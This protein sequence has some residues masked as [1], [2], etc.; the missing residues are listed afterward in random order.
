VGDR[1][2]EDGERFVAER[3]L[4][5]AAVVLDGR[6]QIADEL[7]GLL[8][9]GVRVTLAGDERDE[10]GHELT[11]ERRAAHGTGGDVEIRVVA[12][13]RALEPLQLLA[14]REP[15]LLVEQTAP[16]AVNLK[17]LGLPPRAVERE[18]QLSAE[19]LADGVVAHERLELSD[20]AG[21]RPERKVRVDALLERR[22]P[23]LL[24]PAPLRLHERLVRQ[25]RERVAAPEVERLL[26]QLGP[27]GGG[28]AGGL[29]D[30]CLEPREV[31][32][33][34]S[35]PE[36][37]AGRMRDED[38]RPERL[39]QRRDEVLQRP[40]GL[41]GRL[42]PPERL[43]DAVG[44]EH[45]VRVQE[46]QRQQRARL[47]S[48]EHGRID[49]GNLERPEDAVLHG[50]FVAPASCHEKGVSALWGPRELPP[51]RCKQCRKAP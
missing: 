49:P 33:V 7:C 12:Q 4:Q 5:R 45:F 3:V 30:E 17:R 18:H 10:H 23:Q 47:R 27:L 21:V 44:R 22:E 43:D 28:A 34:G 20:H 13:D 38:V 48:A 25:I 11:R 8:A 1:D 29:R 50:R 2:S 42:L 36:H 46:Q 15:E 24:E 40:E 35:D 31:E 26:Q 16:F 6:A 41:G 19:S 14:R 32:L 9:K 51:R 39:S 37:V